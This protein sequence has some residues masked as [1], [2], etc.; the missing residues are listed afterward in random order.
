MTCKA[1]TVASGANMASKARELARHFDT[2]AH[3]AR[4][5]RMSGVVRCRSCCSL[6]KAAVLAACMR[7]WDPPQSDL[8]SSWGF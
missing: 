2:Q 3:P 7:P 8:T 1:L 5:F 4:P 6:L